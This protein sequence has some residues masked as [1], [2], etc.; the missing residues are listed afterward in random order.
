MHFRVSVPFSFGLILV[1]SACDRNTR[2]TGSP[3]GIEGGTPSESVLLPDWDARLDPAEIERGRLDPAW[4]RIVAGDT[5]AH[6]MPE[7]VSGETLAR[8]SATTVNEGPMVLPLHGEVQGPSVLRTQILLDRALFS[9]G[10]IDGRWGKN[11]EKALYW[12]QHRE[13]LPESGHLD[14][15]TF[16]RLILRAGGPTELITHHVV[17]SEDVEGPFV[18]I[19]DDVYEKAD[20]ECTCYE[21]LAEKLG[22]R[23]HVDPELLEILN[24]GVDIS[25][26]L[27]G[28][29]LQLPIVRD[30]NAARGIEIDRL[31]ISADGFHLHAVDSAGRILLHFPTTLGS[32]FDPS[33]EGSHRVTR[34]THDP[35]W[36]YQPTILAHVDSSEPEAM[37]PPG[38]NNAVGEVWMA[39]SVPHYGIHGTASPETI[40][41]TTS[42]GCVR[43]TNWDARFLSE[44]IRPEVP[45]E[46]I[47]TGSTDQAPG[48]EP[49]PAAGV[50]PESDPR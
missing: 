41:Y 48:A 50:D 22:E 9:P 14:A 20:L 37:V 28:D 36:H 39:L 11:T 5:A 43:L 7:M 10:V 33:P 16:E 26:L 18:T 8:I 19:P 3:P 4:R 2:D 32:S 44:R 1:T 21:N 13:G 47:E 42:A 15:A 27:A 29:S 17:T 38:P 46:F 24:P 45:V 6:A 23:Y 40:G 25:S 31:R 49:D 12:F 30:P 34:I 35:Y